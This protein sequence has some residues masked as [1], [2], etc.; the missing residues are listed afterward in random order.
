MWLG[1]WL[2]ALSLTNLDMVVFTCQLVDSGILF[3][4]TPCPLTQPVL[5]S[6]I[7]QLSANLSSHFALKIKLV[8]FILN[9]AVDLM[10][11]FF[12]TSLCC[13]LSTVDTHTHLT[14]LSTRLLT[15]CVVYCSATVPRIDFL[16]MFRENGV[17]TL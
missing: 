14:T 2:Q 15:R 11:V 5:L 10:R 8:F 12:T 6:L 7:Q 1:G 17:K 13:L 9:S 4:S 16:S 3:N